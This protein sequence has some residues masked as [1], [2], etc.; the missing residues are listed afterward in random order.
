MSRIA[1]AMSGGV[2]SSVAALLLQRQGH[3][4]CGLTMTIWPPRDGLPKAAA[5][6]AAVARHLGIAHRVVDLH[7]RF[8]AEVLGPF[9]AEYASGRTPNPCVICNPRVKFGHLLAAALASGAAAMATGHYVRRDARGAG[10]S[11]RY[12]LRRGVDAGKDQSYALYGLSQ[13]QLRLAVFPLG[14]LTKGDVRAMA[15]EAGLPVSSKP[16]SQDLCFSQGGYREYLRE[17]LPEGWEPGPICDR[18]GNVIG[19][20]DGIAGYTVGQRRGLGVAAGEPLYVIEICP[21]SRTL[22]VGP[23]ADLY[24]AGLLVTACNWMAV[25]ELT[26]ELRATVKIRYGGP[27]APGVLTPCPDRPGTVRVAFDRPQR[28]ITPGQAAVFYCGD[29]VL[30]GGTIAAP[31][32]P[33]GAP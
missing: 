30:G 27:A 18:D 21:R 7:S 15:A 23:E 32:G 16:E 3:E 12:F 19:Q 25:P 24:R 4:V 28:A 31:S 17:R 1:V 11:H 20:H 5:D 22:V 13:E 33:P 8:L 29:V 2:D 9:A 26:A 10:A 6:A 14:G